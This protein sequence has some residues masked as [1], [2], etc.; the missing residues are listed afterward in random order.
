M[1]LAI[2]LTVYAAVLL[3]DFRSLAKQCA[4]GVRAL[5][6]TLLSIS[7]AVLT[8]DEL[9]VSVPSPAKPIQQAI[10]ALFGIS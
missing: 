5:Y 8:L 2:L 4:P 10:Q 7:F 1:M 9:G 3:V 6:L